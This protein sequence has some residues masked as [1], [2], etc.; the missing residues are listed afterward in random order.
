MGCWFDDDD[1]LTSQRNCFSFSQLVIGPWQGRTLFAGASVCRVNYQQADDL[2][3][4][5]S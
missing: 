4:A 2:I 1:R 3:V 5:C